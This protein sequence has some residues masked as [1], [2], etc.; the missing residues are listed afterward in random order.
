MRI[1]SPSPGDVHL[2]ERARRPVPLPPGSRAGSAAGHRRHAGPGAP[3]ASSRTR[4]RPASAER[5]VRLDP[6]DSRT[7]A[8]CSA[9]SPYQFGDTAPPTHSPIRNGSVPHRAS[10]FDT[11]SRRSFLRRAHQRRRPLEL[12]RGKQPQ[13]VAH[14][15]RD[16]AV[17][18][19]R[20]RAGADDTLQPPDRER[21]GS[22]AQVRLGLAAAGRE[23]QQVNERT[24]GMR[25]VRMNAVRV[26]RIGQRGQVQQDERE[27]ERPP[28]RHLCPLF[29]DLCLGL[30]VSSGPRFPGAP[31]W[32]CAVAAGPS[33]GWR[34]GTP[35]SALP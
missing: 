17:A 15:H 7:S 1:G 28:R 25:G 32:W 35:S 10:P 21:I 2:G 4:G 18:A 33:P 16:P 31:P 29:F 30:R 20:L 12:L 27:L 22:Q 34:N 8:T 19:A 13:R 3:A 9:A 23:E 5:P 11:A 14:Q 26:C 24:G 6:P